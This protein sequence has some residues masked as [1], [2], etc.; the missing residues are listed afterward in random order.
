[1][2]SGIP[3]SGIPMQTCSATGAPIHL[4]SLE[5]RQRVARGSIACRHIVRILSLLSG[6]PVPI[7]NVD[8]TIIVLDSL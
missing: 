8:Y 6:Y 1:V 5:V 7:T 2:L 4:V 3:V